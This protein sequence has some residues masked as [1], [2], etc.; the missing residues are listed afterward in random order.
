M[1]KLRLGPLLD[2]KAAKITVELNSRTMRDLTDYAA[3]H[4][5]Q[6]GM[7][8]PLPIEK[9]IGPMLDRFMA[10]DRGFKRLRLQQKK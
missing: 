5:E 3:A 6:N 1:T 9:L 2:D 7:S 8:T 10:S 4:A